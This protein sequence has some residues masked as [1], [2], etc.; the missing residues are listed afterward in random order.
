MRKRK[1]YPVVR[2]EYERN[3]DPWI[4]NFLKEELALVEMQLV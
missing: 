2:L 3:P 4:V 1:H